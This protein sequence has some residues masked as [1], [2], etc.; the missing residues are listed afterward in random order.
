MRNALHELRAKQR[1]PRRA[2]N[3][4]LAELVAWG[5]ERHRQSQRQFSDAA[6]LNEST[7]SKIL[8]WRLTYVTEETA[9]KLAKAIGCKADDLAKAMHKSRVA[10]G[11]L[12]ANTEAAHV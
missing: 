8:N 3:P 10:V 6:G 4:S 5:M 2:K 12:S 1:Q 9:A 11:R 7:V